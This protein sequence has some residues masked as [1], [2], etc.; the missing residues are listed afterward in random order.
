M[1]T[2]KRVFPLIIV[3]VSDSMLKAS[4]AQFGRIDRQISGCRSRQAGGGQKV[5][6]PRSTGPGYQKCRQLSAP[7][8]TVS[9]WKPRFGHCQHTPSRHP[10][11][12]LLAA[13]G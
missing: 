11:Q 7:S 1:L 4:E 6:R 3:R 12:I 2:R 8:M 10:Q 5:T 13:V 9:C